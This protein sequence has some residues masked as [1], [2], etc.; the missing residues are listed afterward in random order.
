VI[1]RAVI[2]AE[3]DT[4]SPKELSLASDEAADCAPQ[5]QTLEEMEKE[6]IQRVLKEADGNQSKASQV[7]GIDRKTLYHKLK[8]YGIG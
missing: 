8:K 7:L 5:P 3:R 1:E 2:L 4:I 6:H